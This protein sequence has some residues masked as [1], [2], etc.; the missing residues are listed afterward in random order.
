[1]NNLSEIA[2]SLIVL[3]HNAEELAVTHSKRTE[4]IDVIKAMKIYVKEK[5]FPLSEEYLDGFIAV[6]LDSRSATLQSILRN[7]AMKIAE[8]DSKIK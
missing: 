7:I 8:T 3:T 4:A 1:M 6:A 2:K 5:G